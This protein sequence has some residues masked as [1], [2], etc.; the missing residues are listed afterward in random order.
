MNEVAA[1]YQHIESVIKKLERERDNTNE[2]DVVKFVR[3]KREIA[4]WQYLKFCL[5]NRGE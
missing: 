5:L 1:V 2:L 4:L 3:I